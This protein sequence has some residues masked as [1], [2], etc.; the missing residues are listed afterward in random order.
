MSNN[1]IDQA[2]RAML[3]R[4]V[5]IALIALWGIFTLSWLGL[6]ITKPTVEGVIPAAAITHGVGNRY[7]APL[8]KAVGVTGA[9]LLPSDGAMVQGESNLRVYENQRE[10]GPAH[11]RHDEVAE[12]GGGRF[13]HWDRVLVFSTP[14][15]SDP[16]TNGRIYSVRG[17]IT[18]PLWLGLLSALGAVCFS[19]LA[20]RRFAPALGRE[21]I[22]ESM[23]RFF[24]P[25]PAKPA[26][27]W[28]DEIWL[29]IFALAGAAIYA[30][31]LVGGFSNNMTVAGYFPISDASNYWYCATEA[32]DY[33]HTDYWCHR[34][35][36][37]SM[38]A[39]GLSLLSGRNLEILLF[40]QA[41]ILGACAFLFVRE[42]R[43]WLGT[44]G[45][46]FVVIGVLAISWKL[47]FG[48]VTSEVLGLCLG[49]VAGAVLLRAGERKSASLAA[50][51][52][53]VFALG[54][55]A[56][57]GALLA[58]PL[59]LAWAATLNGLQWRAVA[60]AAGLAALAI[61][62]AFAVHTSL[63]ALTGGDPSS[64]A[65]NT[66]A[67]IYGLSVGQDW[68][69]LERDHPE[70]AAESPENI[71]E[72]YRLALANMRERPQ[73]V[74]GA[75]INNVRLHL[76]TQWVVI[77][78]PN[79]SLRSLF[80]ICLFVTALAALRDRRALL[81]LAVVVGELSSGALTEIDAIIRLWVASGPLAQWL[82]YALTIVL[83][84]RWLINRLDGPQSVPAPAPAPSDRPF[85]WA[86]GLVG[87]LIVL[88]I[89]HLP[90]AHGADRPA[91]TNL[92]AAGL[93]TY[94]IDLREA[95]TLAFTDTAVPESF[96]RRISQRALAPSL[97]MD[98][99]Y[100]GSVRSLKDVRL[101][102]ALPAAP[103]TNGIGDF[104]APLD[105]DLP[106][107]G[108]IA[109]CA[110]ER[111]TIDAAGMPFR[112]IVSVHRL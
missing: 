42:V 110:D 25:A 52:I 94:E 33:G 40:L 16:R 92:C 73:V 107:D 74:V 27:K 18:P 78:I 17:T 83:A 35:P 48:A 24:N 93:T 29:G 67:T 15:N 84:A 100:G 105:L 14:D 11:A 109:I 98:P 3:R 28:V 12:L 69:A 53:F 77:L 56:R 62:G 49:F 88:P 44:F 81:V 41:M 97:E 108:P 30:F 22:G 10:I 39:A 95:A 101:I 79:L 60:K 85:F 6:A 68:R 66:P 57:P 89:L 54:Q 13:S 9:S 71:R 7:E 47:G 23:R 31:M 63:V 50:W 5:A 1:E 4:G 43:R 76:D 90:F 34:R 38:F 99:L 26:G 80:F 2:R 58:L 87:A 111:Q 91:H 32:L 75:V 86:T 102:R 96:P 59:L 20:L 70:L 8:K 72:T 61:A 36:V 51:G 46:G 64:S 21:S 82:P 45:A 104:Y 106:T 55:M 103:H 112:R 19:Y 65:G 37:Y